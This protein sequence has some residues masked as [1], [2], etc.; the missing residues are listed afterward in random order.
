[1]RQ[2]AGHLNDV[3]RRLGLD[4]MSLPAK[5]LAAV[6]VLGMVVFNVVVFVLDTFSE[7]PSSTGALLFLV[8]PIY[9]A[10]AVLALFAVDW[11]LRRAL[12]ELRQLRR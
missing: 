7:D 11:I 4:R 12:N 5:L 2:L 9:A 10:L 8:M 3:F 1:M 6:V